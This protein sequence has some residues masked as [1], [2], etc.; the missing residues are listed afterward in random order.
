MLLHTADLSN[1]CK[2]WRIHVQ[3]THAILAEFFSQ[4][5]HTLILKTRTKLKGFEMPFCT[6]GSRVNVF[7]GKPTF[8]LVGLDPPLEDP[9]KEWRIHVQ[10]THA[11]LAEFFSQVGQT[12]ILKT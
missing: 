11:I 3:W 8:T 9:C 6:E 5:G 2:E 4:V 1:P 10:W 12:L 7:Y